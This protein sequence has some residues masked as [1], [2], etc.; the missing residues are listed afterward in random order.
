MKYTISTV[1]VI[2]A[3]SNV[4]QQVFSFPDNREGNKSAERCFVREAMKHCM[5]KTDAHM[6][7]EDGYYGAPINKFNGYELFLVHSEL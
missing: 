5:R 4:V 1:N 6:C 7:L 3:W 2:A